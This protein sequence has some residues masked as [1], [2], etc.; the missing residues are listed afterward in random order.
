ML[1][2]KAIN[3]FF[4]KLSFNTNLSKT[5]LNVVLFYLISSFLVIGALAIA[6]YHFEKEQYFNTKKQKID[7]IANH[8]I[9]K[10]QHIHENLLFEEPI[11]YPEIENI[12]TAIFDLDKHLLYSTL[13]NKNINLNYSFEQIDQNQYYIYKIEPYYLGA[14]YLVI[15]IKTDPYLQNILKMILLLSLIIGVFLILSS[16]FIAKLL[17]KPLSN[18]TK[19]LERFLKDTTHELNTPLSVILNNLEMI[20]KENLEKKDRKRLQRI[21]VAAKTITSI[22]DDL[23]YFLFYKKSNFPTSNLSLS[24]ILYERIEFFLAMAELKK[25]TFTLNIEEDIYLK[26]NEQKIA[27]VFDNLLSNAIKYSPT[28]STIILV[29]KQNHFSITDKGK[30]MSQKQIQEVFTRYK[31]FDNTVGGFGIGYSIIYTIVQE[32]NITIT[33]DSQV[34]QGT[35]VTLQW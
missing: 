17:I 5:I 4:D 34:N 27:R 7:L 1:R 21:E 6:Y 10:L 14:A 15:E 25:I 22:Y 9:N 8:F 19:T 31:R 23:S 16:L 29:L 32:Y 3:L 2:N 35:K 18:N 11:I 20:S 26:I 12:K 30:G 33:I 28:H 24:D 13:S